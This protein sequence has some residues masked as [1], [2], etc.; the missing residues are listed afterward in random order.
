M[1]RIEGTFKSL[2]IA[3]IQW[4]DYSEGRPSFP[5][6]SKVKNNAKGH[7]FLRGLV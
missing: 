3:A 1:S 6:S 2:K 4:K 5:D 7:L